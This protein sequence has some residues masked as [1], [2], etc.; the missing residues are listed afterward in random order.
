MLL[1]FVIWLRGILLEFE[2][3]QEGI[4]PD[5]KKENPIRKDDQG[6]RLLPCPGEVHQQNCSLRNNLAILIPDWPSLR[7]LVSELNMPLK[8]FLDLFFRFVMDYFQTD[9]LAV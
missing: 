8:C 1:A 4:R 6:Y 7:N 2:G 3:V 9:F 5:H